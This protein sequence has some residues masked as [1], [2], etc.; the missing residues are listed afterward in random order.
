MAAGAAGHSAALSALLRAF[1]S[2]EP[3]HEVLCLQARPYAAIPDVLQGAFPELA[4]VQPLN[5]GF[6]TI[7]ACPRAEVLRPLTVTVAQMKDHD[8]L[9]KIFEA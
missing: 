3:R 7:R 2:A 8:D 5:I 9:V 4:P 1:F 6:C